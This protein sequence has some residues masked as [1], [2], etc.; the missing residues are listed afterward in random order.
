MANVVLAH[1]ALLLRMV[2]KLTKSMEQIPRI[3][4]LTRTLPTSAAF[5]DKER[6][7]G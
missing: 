2:K 1:N 7:I 6:R 4:V 5:L 3:S